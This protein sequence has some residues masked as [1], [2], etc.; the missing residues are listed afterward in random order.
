MSIYSDLNQ[1]DPLN[2]VKLIDIESIYQSLDNIIYTE[3]GERMFLP[4]FGTDI[5]EHI[6]DPMTKVHSSRILYDI[7]ASVS[8]WEP[9]VSVVRNKSSINTSPDSHK[10]DAEIVFTIVGLD[11]TEYVYQTELSANLKGEYYAV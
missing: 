8:K 4:E 2:D 10:V 6:F 1:Q 3:K 11:K 9:R 5:V 7:I